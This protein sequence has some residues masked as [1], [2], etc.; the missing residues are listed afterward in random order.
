M[1]STGIIKLIFRTPNQNTKPEVE[2][3]SVIFISSST[4]DLEVPEDLLKSF[5][6]TI[7][8]VPVYFTVLL[9]SDSRL[10]IYHQVGS[11]VDVF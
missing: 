7:M 9:E 1:I 6:V 11:L 10:L 2:M 3:E 4:Q 5:T 8:L